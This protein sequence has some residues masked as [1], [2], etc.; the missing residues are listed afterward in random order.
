MGIAEPRMLG[1]SFL[2]PHNV[3]GSMSGIHAKVQ[4]N[5]PQGCPVAQ[6]SSATG[7]KTSSVTKSVPADPL[8]TVTEE[9][10]VESEAPLDCVEAGAAEYDLREVFAYGGERSYRFDRPQQR[11]CPCE[12]IEQFGIPILDVYSRNGA[13]VISF[14]VSDMETLRA[15]IAELNEAASGVS[16]HRLIRSKEE[17]DEQDLVLVDRSDLTER[18]REVMTTAE[19]MGYFEHPKE[20]NAG[21]VAE[22]L[23]ITTSTFTEHLAAAQRKLLSTILAE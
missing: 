1:V 18:Q 5:S 17:R 14:H 13:L 8:D 20:A 6:A 2:L 7:S 19:E 9:F 15:A 3:F 22:A 4:I 16:V 11:R 21:E 12:S 10:I 23:G